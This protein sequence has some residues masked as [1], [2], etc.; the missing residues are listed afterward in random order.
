M[1]TLTPEALA[2]MSTHHGIITASGLQTCKVSA[3]SRKR[4][5]AAGVLITVAKGVYRIASAPDVLE[6]RCV[7]LCCAHPTGFVTGPTGGKFRS[8]RRQPKD[9][10]VHFCVP[11]GH[12]LV[13]EGVRVR[14]SRS[15]DQSQD[16]QVR[17]DGIRLATPWRLAFDLAAD[18]SD[19]DHRSVVEQLIADGHCGIGAL[20]AVGKRLASPR[21]PGSERFLATLANRLPGG[22]LESHPEVVLAEALSAGGVP[23][24]AQAPWLTLPGGR[25]IR[26]D[27][28]VPDIR[29][30]VEVD[31]H[32][33]HFMLEGGSADRD[34][35]RKCRRIGWQ[36]ERVTALDLLVLSTIVDELVDLYRL[37]CLEITVGVAA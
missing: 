9:D 28:S 29:W 19:T 8:L 21:R 20:I 24:H 17:A 32:F 10:E 34:R 33:S 37:R 18:L 13:L 6:S 1:T 5:V 15:V 12:E 30:G 3:R 36:I 4:L 7:A 25:R 31:V 16:V 2:W 35:D 23:L 27:M 11:H 14:Q 26:L 22:P